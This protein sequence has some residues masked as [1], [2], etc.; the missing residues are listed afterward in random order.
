MI[1][2]SI[3]LMVT[4]T[5]L[6]AI[7]RNPKRDIR[8][9][10]LVT[11]QLLSQ[12]CFLFSIPYLNQVGTP[13]NPRQ[14][15]MDR[16][17]RVFGFC[18]TTFF[19]VLYLGGFTL[20]NLSTTIKNKRCLLAFGILELVIILLFLLLPTILRSSL[21]FYYSLLFMAYWNMITYGVALYRIWKIDVKIQKL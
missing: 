15:R 18:L 12:I 8:V 11:A 19:Y 16:L 1:L 21:F 13:T 14:K 20:M 9:F 5:L 4:I 6:V 2:I 17:G 10:L 7:K 3:S